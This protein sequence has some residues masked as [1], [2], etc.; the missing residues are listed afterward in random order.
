MLSLFLYG[1]YSTVNLLLK[2]TP[3]R[4]LRPLYAGLFFVA[5]SIEVSSSHYDATRDSANNVSC[6]RCQLVNRCLRQEIAYCNCN[7]S[8]IFDG[9]LSLVY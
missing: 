8:S 9:K 5:T 6:G 4:A 3:T 7:D 2:Q 1:F